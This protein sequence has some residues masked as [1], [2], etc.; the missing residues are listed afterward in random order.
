MNMTIAGL[1]LR[2]LLGRKR[3]WLLLPLPVVLIGLTLVG[4]FAAE[5]GDTGWIDPVVRGL[6]FNVVVPILSLIIG[7]SVVGSE[8]D[9]GT[10]VHLLTKPLSRAE[11]L[12]AK[13]V[14]AAVVTAAV[15]GVSMFI[16]GAIA[17]DT[18]FGLAVALAAVVASIVYCALFV[19]LSVV[20]RRP[21]LIGIAYILLWEGL[22]TGIIP[23]TR[24]LAVNQ[25]ALT[26]AHHAGA[27][28]LDST[29][30]VPTAAAMSAVLT[31]AATALAIYRL[32]SFTLAGETS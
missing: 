8:I 31:V 26:I 7:A 4:H 17:V 22:L 6:G 10:L 30:S 9:D 12:I 23:G 24:S 21:V 18:S 25:Y 16:A 28:T 20:S 27:T 19:A 5:A 13:F 2:S 1:T 3:V 15:T 11:I 32:R 14:V 29:V